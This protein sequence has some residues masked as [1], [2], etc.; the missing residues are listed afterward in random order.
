MRTTFTFRGCVVFLVLLG[1][2]AL[3]TAQEAD[4]KL[5]AVFKSY[6][7][8]YFRLRL[9]EATRLGDHRFDTQL[10][11]LTPEA[12]A[13]WLEHTKKTLATLPKEVSY[14]ELSR[15]AQIDFEILEHTLKADQWLAENTH[16]YQED[17]RI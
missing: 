2:A 11:E 4:A 14:Q 16:P 6:L 9:M 15:P 10:E 5:E 8:D 12:R 1:N 3:V 17:T 7:D 13:K